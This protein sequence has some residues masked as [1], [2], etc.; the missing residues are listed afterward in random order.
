M[1]KLY[2]FRFTENNNDISNKSNNSTKL[3]DDA[4]KYS[5]LVLDNFYNA[6]MSNAPTRSWIAKQIVES[7]NNDDYTVEDG[8]EE[9]ALLIL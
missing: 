9:L 1:K 4:I 5:D 7:L 8:L 6:D 3:L 2:K